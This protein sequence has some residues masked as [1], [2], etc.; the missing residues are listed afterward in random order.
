MQWGRPETCVGQHG[1]PR[2]LLARPGPSRTSPR[3][4]SVRPPMR[5]RPHVLPR[6]KARAGPQGDSSASGS[7][8]SSRRRFAS[9]FLTTSGCG[10]TSAGRCLTAERVR[11][12]GHQRAGVRAAFIQRHDWSGLAEVGSAAGLDSPGG[13]APFWRR[14]G[15]HRIGSFRSSSSRRHGKGLPSWPDRHR[16]C[17]SGTGPPPS[18]QT[19]RSDAHCRQSFAGRWCHW[20]AR[21]PARVAARS[22]GRNAREGASQDGPRAG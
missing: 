16:R 18:A 14:R 21:E 3:T 10:T 1:M 7:V 13:P 12:A 15:V 2:T 17:S 22:A 6:Q 9:S 20:H 19:G 11:P 5:S 4:S 8:T